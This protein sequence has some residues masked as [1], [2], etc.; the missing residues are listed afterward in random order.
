[1]MD[2]AFRSMPLSS[3]VIYLD[4]ILVYSKTIE[5]HL[6]KLEEM[7]KIL[8]AN[9]LFLRAD[10]TVVVGKEVIFVASE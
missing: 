9:R 7:F 10:K 4:D 3:L 1:M 5:D 2:E 8:R 6:Q